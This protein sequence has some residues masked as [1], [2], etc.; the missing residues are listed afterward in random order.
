MVISLHTAPTVNVELGEFKAEAFMGWLLSS[1]Y[2]FRH[3]GY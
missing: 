2:C 3:L 1:R